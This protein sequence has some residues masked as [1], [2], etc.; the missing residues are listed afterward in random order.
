MI[1]AWSS[2]WEIQAR[3]RG[4]RHNVGAA[5][6]GLLVEVREKSGRRDRVG[7]RRTGCRR[8]VV[9]AF[10]TTYMNESGF[11]IARDAPA[12]ARDPAQ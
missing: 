5:A 2:G 8:R 6:V 4:T 7:R 9:L 12:Q 11:A 1:D 10:P 3:I